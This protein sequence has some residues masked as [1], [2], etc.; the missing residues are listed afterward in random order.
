[1][2]EIRRPTY[3]NKRGQVRQSRVWWIRY[4]RDG[5]RYEES[6]GSTKETEARRLLKLREGDIAKGAPVTPQASRLTFDDAVKDVL[7]D[8][9]INGKRSLS[10]VERRIN[11]HLLPAFG[12]RRM[13][14]IT[15]ADI[16]AFIVKRQTTIEHEDGTKTPGASNGE[17]NRELAIVKRAFR[18]AVQG[19]KLFQTTYVPMLRESNVRAG[20]FE[21]SEFTA[22]RAALPA[23]LRPVVT[24]AYLTGWR[25]PSEVLTLQWP[26]VDREAKTIRLEPGTAKNREGRTFPYGVLPEL[27][28]VITDQWQERERLK[29]AGTICP[30]VFHRAGK[31][32]SDLYGAWRAA[33]RTA[34]VPG[35]IPHDFRRTAVRNLVRAGVP[36]KTAMQLTGHKTRSVFDRYDIV[37]ESDL[38][39]AV[40]KLAESVAGKDQG[41]STRSSRVAPFRRA[42][43]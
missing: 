29:T 25:I 27:E 14:A 38:R 19:G 5:R 3:T 6:S 10:D 17:V 30:Y 21:R 4:Y 34:G 23:A 31:A 36:E 40:E 24:F 32:I 15:T 42:R 12:G 13:S 28:D 26:Q 33:C 18:L 41:K 39:N 35:R 20:F 8:Y 1:M 9:R 22:V 11:L 16:R 43:K 7:N 2:G 37:S